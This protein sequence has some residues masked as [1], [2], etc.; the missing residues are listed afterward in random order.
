ME[1]MPRGIRFSADGQSIAA[2]TYDRG[3]EIVAEKIFRW[4]VDGQPM[5]TAEANMENKGS[6]F[7]CAMASDLSFAAHGTRDADS[8]KRAIRVVY[9]EQ[10]KKSWE[11]PLETSGELVESVA[12]SLDDKLLAVGLGAVS[13]D[14][15]IWD[16]QR[17]VLLQRLDGHLAYVKDLLFLPDGKTLASAS[18]DQSVR[19]WDL[20]DLENVPPP[21]VL[22]GHEDEV[23]RLAVSSDGTRLVSG[24]R[25]GSAF[26]WDLSAKDKRA[27]SGFSFSRRDWSFW[28]FKPDKSAL[29]SCNLDGS[30]SRWTGAQFDREQVVLE[31]DD[32]FHG[33]CVSHDGTQVAIGYVDGRI[34]LWDIER[35][36]VIDEFATEDGPMVPRQFLAGGEKLAVMHG[37]WG[38]ALSLWDLT[39]KKK[40]GTWPT[41]VIRF[42]PDA[43]FCLS[44]SGS[45]DPWMA[46]RITLHNLLTGKQELLPESWQGRA[47]QTAF[48]ADACYLAASTRGTDASTENEVNVWDLSTRKLIGTFGRFLKSAHSVNFSPDRERLIA[49]SGSFEAVRLWDI[50][51]QQELLT[52][53]ANAGLLLNV[54]FH[55][56]GDIISAFDQDET[57]YCWRAPSFEEIEEAEADQ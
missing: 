35:R 23:S 39:N 57:V 13:T 26:V 30:V 45:D 11:S 20:S 41:S 42:S 8:K 52:L 44:F 29:I 46:N 3:Q 15:E 32:T 27:I 37:G 4:S 40:V 47:L 10:E 22:Q 19:L 1:V 25:D 31:F 2:M 49:A 33:G 9:F 50:Q 6:G 5:S 38:G 51:S 55:A 56:N 12:L 7:S 54:R 53:P 48:S 21:R 24:C 36:K 34:K 14:I 17:G 18:A 28:N 43:R 16:V